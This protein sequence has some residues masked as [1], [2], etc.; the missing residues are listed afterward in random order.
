MSKKDFEL[1]ALVIAD[2]MYDCYNGREATRYGINTTINKLQ[3]VYP[4][5]DASKFRA[6]I[7]VHLQAI[8]STAVS[9]VNP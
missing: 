3:L 9:L 5:F 7:R 4:N 1:W 8:R 2:I 6:A